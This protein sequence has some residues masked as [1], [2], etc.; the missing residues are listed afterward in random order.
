MKTRTL[1]LMIV[2][3]LLGLLVMAG[4]VLARGPADPSAAPSAQAPVGTGFSYQGRLDQGGSPAN[5]NFDLRF[6]LF[7]AKVSG[8]PVGAPI[9][10]EDVPI[11][12][13]LFTVIL[14][15]GSVFDGGDRW[16]QIEVRPGAETGAFTA[17][18]PLQKLTAVPYAQFETNDILRNLECAGGQVAKGDGA[19]WGCSADATGS[20]GIG[21]SGTA[22][23]IAKF[24][25]AED[26]GDSVITETGGNVGIG[27]TFPLSRLHVEGPNQTFGNFQ[28]VFIRTSSASGPNRG[29]GIG[30]GGR[31][32]SAGGTTG[33]A[34]IA[35][36]KEN[37]TDGNAAGY[38]GFATNNGAGAIVEKVRI[39]SDGNVGIG[40]TSPNEQLEITGNFSLPKSTATEGVIKSD[41]DRFIH[42]FGTDNFFSGVNA[43][44]LTMTGVQNTGV[45]ANALS[46]NTTGGGNTATGRDALQ[47]NT[48]GSTNTA[49]GAFALSSNTTGGSNT[50]AGTQALL[51]NTTGFSNTA[52][53]RNALLSNTTGNN[54]T[55][56]GSSALASNTTGFGN[57]ASGRSALFANSTG[58]R[59]T[60]TG[61]EALRENT[62]G[63][64]NTATG[65]RALESNTTGSNNTAIGAF[66]DVSAGNLTNATAIGN[67]ATVDASNKI[68]LGNTA[69]TVI[70]GQVAFT[71][72]SDANQKENFLGV[73]GEETLEKIGQMTLESWNYKGHDPLQFR[74]YGPTAQDFF[75]AFGD[76]GFGVV[77]TETTIN[78]G[79]MA[80]IL[81]IAVQALEKRTAQIAELEQLVRELQVQMQRMEERLKELGAF[82]Q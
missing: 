22:G 55:A 15:F 10:L 49:T 38:L 30:F 3:L 14:D 59:N 77:G 1:L 36:R 64:R 73:D 40:T 54:N 5:G 6:S 45:G 52:T 32:S 19:A 44:N 42:N 24:T 53:G 2:P 78:S 21:G 81:M 16:L 25:G 9:D 48:S 79:D 51:F 4:V 61:A 47:A 75:A 76:D 23:K 17:L 63:A 13:G 58:F 7:D 27:E 74:H 71:F 67:G 62:T 20:G 35:G 39:T 41:G 29:G 26:I 66:A 8:A 28:N 72:T 46:S 31:F 50:A 56:G 43:G 33:F 12:N 80:G 60:A 68:R 69:V 11:E 82:E 65:R 37:P 34:A 57:T 18:S 70:E